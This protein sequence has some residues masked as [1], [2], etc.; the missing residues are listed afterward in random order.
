MHKND[1]PYDYVL[2]DFIT[3]HELSYNA[4]VTLSVELKEPFKN[5]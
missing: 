5:P 4:D 1:S 3:L 2:N